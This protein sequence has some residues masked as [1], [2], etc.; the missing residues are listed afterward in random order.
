L[1]GSG[2]ENKGR[3][4]RAEPRGPELSRS[5]R[6]QAGN[7]T[8]QFIPGSGRAGNDWR[9]KM[10]LLSP[11]IKASLV[12]LGM[13]SGLST[14]ALAAPLLL[15]TPSSPSIIAAPEI[16]PARAE[17]AGNQQREGANY[18]K[19]RHHW[20]GERWRRN[21]WRHHYRD[22]W[23]RHRHYRRYYGGSG[24]YFGL[25]ALGFGPAYDYYA[26]R[27]TYRVYRGSNAHIRWCYNRYRSYRASD[28]TYQPY[29]G[30]RR[31]CISPYR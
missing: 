11:S 6:V 18:W 12:A 19:R 9:T 17:W 30:P 22:D 15:P 14:A 31:Q 29:N 24:I 26:P 3:K 4:A 27:R 21:S 28:N 8:M 10:K 2:D 20:R 13:V 1:P 16:I 7:A 23:R 5:F 25:G